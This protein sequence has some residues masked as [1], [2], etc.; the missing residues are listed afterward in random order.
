MRND[1]LMCHF[2]Y[3]L[4]SRL[5]ATKFQLALK[6]KII[7]FPKVITCYHSVVDFSCSLRGKNYFFCKLSSSASRNFFARKHID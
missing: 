1:S 5:S 6:L 3:L 7:T 4:R 2:M